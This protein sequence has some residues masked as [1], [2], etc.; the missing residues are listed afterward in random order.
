M[1]DHPQPASLQRRFALRWRRE[2]VALGLDPQAQAGYW[3]LAL[4]FRL[5]PQADFL[6]RLAPCFPH[7]DLNRLGSADLVRLPLQLIWLLLAGSAAAA[8]PAP[9]P[10][11]LRRGAQRL[12]ARL[13]AGWRQRQPPGSTLA[14]ALEQLL[15]AA[16]QRRWRRRQTAWLLGGTLLA[17]AAT[18]PLDA[19][20]QALLVALLLALLLAVARGGGALLRILLGCLTLAL[21]LR[22]FWWRASFTLDATE[23]LTLTLGLFLLLAEIRLWADCFAGLRHRRAAFAAATAWLAQLALLAAPAAALLAGLPLIASDPYSLALYALPHLLALRALRARAAARCLYAASRA[24]A[25]RASC[26]PPEVGAGA[27]LAGWLAWANWLAVLAGIALLAGALEPAAGMTGLYLAWAALNL[28]YLGIAALLPD[29]RRTTA[30]AVLPSQALC[31]AF[32]GQARL[33]AASLRLPA[34]WRTRLA[35]WRAALAWWLPRPPL[36]A[37]ALLA[38][39]L[40]VLLPATPVLAQ[41]GDLVSTAELMQSAEVLRSAEQTNPAESTRRLTLK[42]LS[43]YNSLPLRTTDGS[44]AVYFGQRADE[45]VTRV[46]LSLRYSHSPALLPNDSHIKVMLNGEMIGVAPIRKEAEGRALV[47]EF[48]IDPRF[49]TDRNELR[50]RFVGHYT[51]TCEDPLR[52]SLWADISGSSEIIVSYAPLVLQDDLARLP[53][54]F[55]DRRDLRSL[56]LPVVLPPAPAQPTLNAASIVASW[57]GQ[58]A[59]ERGARF[60]A[61]LDLLQPGHAIVFATNADRPAFLRGRAL[62]DG[63]TIE[64]ITNPADG[65]SKLLLVLGRDGIDVIEAAQALVLGHAAMTGNKIVIRSRR[66]EAPLR[67]YDAPN[68]ARS[69]RPTRLGELIAYPQ[70]LQASGH[71]PPPLK[72]ELRTPPDLFAVGRR[73]VPLTLR[74]RYSPPMRGGDNLLTLS[75]NGLLVQSWALAPKP[76]GSGVERLLRADNPLAADE[77]KLVLPANRIKGRN[78]LSFNFAFARYQEGPCPDVPPDDA[79]RALIDPESTLD[80]SGFHHFARMPNLSHFATAGFPFTK[81]ADLSQTVVVLP[82]RPS[83]EE[84][85][86]T[87]NLLGHF[88]RITGVPGSRVRIVGPGEESLLRD[89][90]LLVI[91]AAMGQGALAKWPDYVPADID[92]NIRRI[93]QPARA[94]NFFYDWLGY[95]VEPD[96][97]LASQDK[98]SAT[99]PLALIVGFRSPLHTDRSVVAITA[100]APD[101]LWQATNALNDEL[102]A[103]RVNGSVAFIRGTQVDSFRVGESY[104]VGELPWWV[105]IWFPLST[106]PLVLAL[107]TIAA[108]VLLS[109]ARAWRR[110]WRAAG[111]GR[112]DEEEDE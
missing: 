21:S 69:D 27:T 111:A 19:P 60:P 91:G 85:E 78:R 30:M 81:Y 12:A 106:H 86:T 93:S 11:G 90:D 62:V 84:I 51:Q 35:R 17:T 109:M 110:A 10:A 5:P 100:S 71:Q 53:E 46:R 102:L 23:Q 15:T 89:A 58:L 94:M 9:A 112:D 70:Q 108:V 75:M 49:I 72:L 68:W 24:R 87:L 8:R 96:E 38:A 57:F 18:V 16:T 29:C 98:F 95:M 40:L 82:D 67:A 107:M 52:N 41:L 22:Y 103:E 56:V 92:G 73:D 99:G 43:G 105:A 42:E 77:Q 101:Q 54:P 14:D 36:P 65:I 7:I 37:A 28:A 97:A 33:L 2:L 47:A 59:G 6:A 25:I 63:P 83:H 55:F 48:E 80:L 61:Q 44:M 32:A 39:C 79:R 3:L 50:F 13:D 45:L 1:S 34:M 76:A 64:M 20:D 31:W 66:N 88:G 74:Y 26:F 4:V 104:F